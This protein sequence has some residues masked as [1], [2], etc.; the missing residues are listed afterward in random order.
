[1]FITS[2]QG[3]IPTNAPAAAAFTERAEYPRMTFFKNRLLVLFY[4][5]EP[6][7]QAALWIVSKTAHSQLPAS[8]YR[9]NAGAVCHVLLQQ[10]SSVSF[11]G[12]GGGQK[13]GKQLKEQLIVW[14]FCPLSRGNS[15]LTQQRCPSPHISYTTCSVG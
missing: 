1:M 4:S 11:G 3:H 7:S 2:M 5:S 13:K 10:I 15:N 6:F 8:D 9:F 14:P 12:G